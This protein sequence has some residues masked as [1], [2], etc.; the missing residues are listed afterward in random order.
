MTSDTTGFNAIDIAF[1][2]VYK[3]SISLLL[4]CWTL[5]IQLN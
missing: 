2:F 3:L 4:W 5:Y 1:L